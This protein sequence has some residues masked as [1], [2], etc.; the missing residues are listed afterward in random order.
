MSDAR[1]K[2]SRD[3]MPPDWPFTTGFWV[4]GS[5][6]LVLILAMVA[7]DAAFTSP[8]HISRALAS[9]EI[10]YSI[11]LSLISCT[12]SALLSLVIGLPLGYLLARQHFPGKTLIDT[13]VDIPIVLPPLVV[14]LSL[15]M[16]FQLKI[17][18]RS[19]DDSLRTQFYI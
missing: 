9:P 4:I 1:S 2:L 16:L 15:L 11:K 5:T 10:Q 7:A 12:I 8:S 17:G 19:L 13:I 6:Y 18:G 14:G 3:R